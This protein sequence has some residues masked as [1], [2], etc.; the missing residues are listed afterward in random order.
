MRCLSISSG[1]TRPTGHSLV[2]NGAGVWNGRIGSRSNRFLVGG[3][4]EY[5]FA[6]AVA[7]LIAGSFVALV[8]ALFA[9]FVVGNSFGVIVLAFFVVIAARQVPKLKKAKHHA[10]VGFNFLP[11]YLISLPALVF[12]FQLALAHPLTK[13]SRDRAIANANEFIGE[14]EAYHRQHGIYPVSLQAQNKDYEPGVT[15]I[16]KYLYE[17]HGQ[18]YNLA[19]EQ[20]RF[21]FDRFGTREWVVYNPRDEHAMDSHV[22]W[23]LHSSGAVRS[24]QGWYASGNTEHRHWMYFL[25]D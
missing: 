9:A 18:G 13:Q 20:P 14:I 24:S 15:G 7:S 17:P 21:L 6:F 12:V 23:R 25:F 11:L 5:R 1:Q 10:D 2:H 16:E 4:A 3:D 19:F 8:L 22:A